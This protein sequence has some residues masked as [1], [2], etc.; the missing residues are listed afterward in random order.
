MNPFVVHHLFLRTYVIIA[1]NWGL[2]IEIPVKL[3][4]ITTHIEIDW[5]P[6][7]LTDFLTTP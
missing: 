5:F 3:K 6:S 4:S 2:V 7:T 1:L